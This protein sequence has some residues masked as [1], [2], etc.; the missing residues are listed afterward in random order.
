MFHEPGVFIQRLD[1][2]FPKKNHASLGRSELRRCR[3]PPTLPL[4]YVGKI[5]QTVFSKLR[6]HV[7]DNNSPHRKFHRFLFPFSSKFPDLN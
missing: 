1:S 6:V 7:K 4:H 2:I 3:Q 5:K